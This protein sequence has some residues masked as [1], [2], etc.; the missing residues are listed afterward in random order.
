[1]ACCWLTLCDYGRYSWLR[2][3]RSNLSWVNNAGKYNNVP[4]RPPNATL[5]MSLVDCARKC[6][7][8]GFSST[9]RLSTNEQMWEV[10]FES[11]TRLSFSQTF[12]AT[13]TRPIS[14]SIGSGDLISDHDRNCIYLVDPSSR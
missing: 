10:L 1:M 13:V 12:Q 14:Y 5:T 7:W 9:H 8:E 11:M 6:Q 2:A 3:S 4:D